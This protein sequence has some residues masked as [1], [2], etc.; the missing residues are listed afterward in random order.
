MRAFG[1]PFFDTVQ[2]MPYVAVQSMLDAAAP[3]GRHNYW[4]SGFLR[5]LPDIVGM[6]V[7]DLAR[8]ATAPS[9]FC[10]IEHVHGA[11]TRVPVDAIAF[12]VRA[13]HFHCI[14]VA[15]WDTSDPAARAA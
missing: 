3:Y 5:A 2:A 4:K 8:T 1:R 14:V 7:G 15:S 11:L 12:N 13:E 10:L 9:S 6:I